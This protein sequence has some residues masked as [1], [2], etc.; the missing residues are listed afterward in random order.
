MLTLLHKQ[1]SAWARCPER[2]KANAAESVFFWKYT[3][4][5]DFPLNFQPCLHS[6]KNLLTAASEFQ[7]L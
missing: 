3:E 7:E 5:G 4:R 6:K 1:E 2:D